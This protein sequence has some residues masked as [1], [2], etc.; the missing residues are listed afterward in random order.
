MRPWRVPF[1][2]T[3]FYREPT[4]TLRRGIESR[5]HRR[6]YRILATSPRQAELEARERFELERLESGVGWVCEVVEAK[7]ERMASA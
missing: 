1:L 3:F 7:V 4:Y 6:T 5:L 2:V